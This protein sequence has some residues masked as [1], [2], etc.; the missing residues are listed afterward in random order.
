FRVTHRFVGRC[1]NAEVICRN[2]APTF[3]GDR[4]LDDVQSV[5]PISCPS[6]LAPGRGTESRLL[7]KKS[8]RQG[9]EL[10]W[11]SG[12]FGLWLSDT[13][14]YQRR[15]EL[16][17]AD[18]QEVGGVVCD[19]DVVGRDGN[20]SR[21]QLKGRPRK[22]LIVAHLKELSWSEEVAEWGFS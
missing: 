12:A 8:C 22:F 13:F 15:F 20:T 7:I 6:S 1:L 17:R 10:L 11:S 21:H 4:V 3:F 19:S 16:D 14:T 2:Y 18:L 5:F 9:V